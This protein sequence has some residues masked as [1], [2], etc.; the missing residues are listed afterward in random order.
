MSFFV[1]SNTALSAAASLSISSDALN[2]SLER[3]SAGLKIDGVA[4]GP[5]AAV[6]AAPRRAIQDTNGIVGRVPTERGALR[7][8]SRLFFRARRLA[9][10]D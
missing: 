2:T 5:A 7:R 10:G 9:G 6:V 4:D 1:L 3:L 8:I